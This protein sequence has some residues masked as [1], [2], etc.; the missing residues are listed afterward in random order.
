[1]KKLLKCYDLFTLIAFSTFHI[2]RLHYPK[3]YLPIDII[4]LIIDIMLIINICLL[5]KTKTVKEFIKLT[6]FKHVY[7]NLLSSF[8]QYIIHNFL[9]IFHIIF[10]SHSLLIRQY[11][12][13]IK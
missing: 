13:F 6:Y 11:K 7:Y 1:M 8:C 2:I 9:Y 10:K 4:G 5:I 3:V 12:Y